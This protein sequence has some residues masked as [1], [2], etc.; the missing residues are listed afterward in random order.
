MGS[1]SASG[2]DQLD[3][4]SEADFVSQAR[5]LPEV[6]SERVAEIRAQIQ[7]GKYETSEKL[8]IA[9]ERLLDEIG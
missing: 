5:D 8:D 2:V 9:L 6:R 3:I 7:S 1:A 4:S